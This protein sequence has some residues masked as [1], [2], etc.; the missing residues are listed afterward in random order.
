MLLKFSTLKFSNKL[1]R[2]FNLPGRYLSIAYANTLQL[3]PETDNTP[4][5]LDNFEAKVRFLR[6]NLYPDSLILVLDKTQDLSSAV[7]IFKWAALQKRFNHTADT[8][9]HIILKLG[10]A[11][12]IK[13]MDDFCLNLARDKCQGTEDALASLIDTF[14]R[15]SRLNEA[16]RVVVNMTLGG[17]NPSVNIFN[18]LLGAL[19]KKKNDFQH[20]LFVYKEMVKAGVVPTVDTLNSLIEVLFETRRVES[21]L[22][23]FRRMRKKGCIPNVRTFEIVI[24][25]LTLNDRVDDAVLILHEM[26]E[27]G[28]QPDLSFYTCIAPL[29]CQENRLNEGIQLF[30]QMRASNLAPD[31][32]TCKEL[33]HCLCMNLHLDE[34][35]EILEEMIENHEIPFVDSFVDIVNGF[36]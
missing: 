10:L 29:F 16:I 34:A 7:K 2:C 32:L 27:L 36:C 11:G 23:Q 8:Y 33:I 9:Y 30:R 1:P 31:S 14:V 21:A 12:N 19:V 15:H 22:D 18:D 3:K 25:G 20:V 4:P 24:K 17:Y 35:T 13:E 6:N 26:W 28:C 5:H